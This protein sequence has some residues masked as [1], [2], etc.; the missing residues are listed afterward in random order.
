MSC[1]KCRPHA[2]EK[3]SVVPLDNSGVNKQS[4]SS[5]ASPNGIFKSIFS[6]LIR[7]SPRSSAEALT[8]AREEQ[9]KIAVAELSH[10]L[11][12]V[13]RKRD[14]AVLESSR[15]KHTMGELEKKLN[16]LEIYCHN[17][18]SGL[19]ECSTKAPYQI[20]KTHSM[21]KV[22]HHGGSMGLNDKV[23]E[24]FLASVSEARSSVRLLSR[25]LAMQLRQM[26]GKV[27]E[28][29]SA[30]L[31]PYDIKVSHSKNPR[32]LLL[33][34][35]AILNKAFYEDFESVGFQKNAPNQILN[36]IDRCDA[37][38]E[39]FNLLQRLTW[40]EVLNKG[41]RHFSEDFSR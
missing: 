34:L 16:K 18:K 6:S 36:P 19:E 14:E 1:N 12:Q 30:L 35:E 37:N 32:S 38:F 27:Y 11:I 29:I 40:E 31:Q 4:N 33:Y 5:M 41:T 23:V 17:L 9:W 26:G 7:K 25:S 2:R 13:T 20:G 39:S 22:N 15:L 24:H 8:T 3:I 28:R 21:R 10:K